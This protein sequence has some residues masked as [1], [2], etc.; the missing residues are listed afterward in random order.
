VFSDALH[1]IQEKPI[2]SVFRVQIQNTDKFQP[3]YT[4]SHPKASILHGVFNCPKESENT[5]A[6]VK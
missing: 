2:A 5:T 1:I 3:E 6:G 4:A